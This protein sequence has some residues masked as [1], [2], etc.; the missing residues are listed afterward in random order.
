M[1]GKVDEFGNWISDLGKDYEVKLPNGKVLKV[2]ESSIE[3]NLVDFINS[4]EKDEEVLKNKWFSF[5]RLYFKSG[6]SE[7]TNESKGQLDNIGMILAAYPNVNIKMGGYTDS[8]GE[9]SFNQKLSQ[10]RA[11]IAKR[12]PKKRNRRW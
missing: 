2:Y 6:K 9:E 10:E 7:L 5:D 11:E 1:K 3:R 8:D 12:T 4:G